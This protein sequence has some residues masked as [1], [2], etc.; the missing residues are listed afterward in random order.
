M[1]VDSIQHALL[2]IQ[3]PYC[4]EVL[5]LFC[6]S[7]SF[8]LRKISNK[9]QVIFDDGVSEIGGLRRD[10]VREREKGNVWKGVGTKRAFVFIYLE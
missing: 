6:K 7:L 8:P 2:S 1:E 3:S 9:A 4:L 5:I 10:W